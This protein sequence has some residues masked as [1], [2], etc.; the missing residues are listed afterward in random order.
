[1]SECHHSKK[2]GCKRQ[3][4]LLLTAVRHHA[5]YTQFS[6]T[7]AANDNYLA[8]SA[9]GCQQAERAIVRKA[10]TDWQIQPL[11]KLTSG[12][13]FERGRG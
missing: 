6:E 13:R 5:D 12:E 2:Q 4:P 8:A 3:K 10:V 11:T 7:I 9:L 1:M